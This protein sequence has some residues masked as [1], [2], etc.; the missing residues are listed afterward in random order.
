METP[1]IESHSEN[2]TQELHF[3]FL[4]FEECRQPEINAYWACFS[5]TSFV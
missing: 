1:K 4:F 2:S 5:K 3:L